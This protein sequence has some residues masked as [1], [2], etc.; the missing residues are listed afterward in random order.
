LVDGEASESE[1]RERIARE[2]SAS[3]RRQILDFDVRR[4]NRGIPED[5]SIL[6]RDVRDSEMVTKLVL[7][8]EPM[9]EAIEVNVA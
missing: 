8:S 5:G 7:S 3:G 1:H 2:R 4:G 9:E 6:H